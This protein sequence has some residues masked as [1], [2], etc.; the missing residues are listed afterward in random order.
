MEGHSWD[1][2][3]SLS[4]GYNQD[5][6]LDRVASATSQVLSGEACYERDSVC[7]YKVEYSFAPMTFLLMLAQKKEIRVVDFGGSL[8]S[9]FLQHR[10]IIE[11]ANITWIVVEQPHF[12][13]K[14]RE[15]LGKI[16]KIQF[17]SSLEKALEKCDVFFCSS[18]LQYIDLPYEVLKVVANSSVSHLLFDRL[19][20]VNSPE[21]ILALQTVPQ[22]IYEA[23]YPCRFFSRERW[24]NFLKADFQLKHEFPSSVPLEVNL[25]NNKAIDV[26]QFWTR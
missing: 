11:S 21:D 19:S 6:I 23:S 25:K 3:K 20:L 16:D 12:V 10:E 24:V 7:F 8:G 22:S 5:N 15:L 1:E 14:G 17:E 26:G 9:F 4:K 2:I 13:E 18:T